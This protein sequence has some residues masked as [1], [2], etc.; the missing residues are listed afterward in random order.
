MNFEVVYSFVHY[1][2][3]HLADLLTLSAGVHGNIVFDMIRHME[4]VG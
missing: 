1:V 2:E 4:N 3:I